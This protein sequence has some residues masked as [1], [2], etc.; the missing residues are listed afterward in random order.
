[1]QYEKPLMRIDRYELTQSIAACGIKIGYSDS[2]CVINDPDSPE[3][4]IYMAYD[5]WFSTGCTF[6]P[7]AGEENDGVCYHTNANAMFNS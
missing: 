6:K 1:M 4:Q 3:E 2:Q 5:N 7:T